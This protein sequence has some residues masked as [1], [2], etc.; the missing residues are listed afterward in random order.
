MK[1]DSTPHIV[2]HLIFLKRE[3]LC[4]V[5]QIF[6]SDLRTM[7]SWLYTY[8]QNQVYSVLFIWGIQFQLLFLKI[9][10]N[11]SHK[12]NN[13]NLAQL[14]PAKKKT[15]KGEGKLNDA[16]NLPLLHELMR[17]NIIISNES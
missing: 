3:W 9:Y 16:N 7:V 10:V 11:Q 13:K 17:L 14:M 2:H 5:S 4:R 12:E 1:E 6:L 8:T 15:K